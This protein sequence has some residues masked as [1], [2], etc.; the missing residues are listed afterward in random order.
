MAVKALITSPDDGF[1]RLIPGGDISMKRRNVLIGLAF[2]GL[3]VLCGYFFFSIA[4]GGSVFSSIVP[5]TAITAPDDTGPVEL[6][7]VGEV[8]NKQQRAELDADEITYEWKMKVPRFFY[9]GETDFGNR[10]SE[11]QGLRNLIFY[12]F[13]EE[14][15]QSFVPAITVDEKQQSDAAIINVNNRTESQK[16][17]DLGYCLRGLDRDRLFYGKNQYSRGACSPIESIHRCKVLS[18]YKGWSIN[19][20]MPKKYYFGDY[21]KFCMA[22][23]SFFDGVT[24][25]IRPMLKSAASVGR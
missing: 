7:I 18:H 10:S 11:G 8:L 12:V 15:T 5:S 3:A 21:K 24:T 1:F 2:V 25:E 20:L 16:I 19:I 14:S 13:F 23:D 4:S 17:I 6:H 9:R 22:V